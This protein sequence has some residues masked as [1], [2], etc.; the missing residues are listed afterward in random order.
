[1][2]SVHTTTQAYREQA[3]SCRSMAAGAP[4]DELR[5]QWFRLAESYERTAD[6][7]LPG[8]PSRVFA[9]RRPPVTL[10]PLARK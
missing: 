9:A 6:A 4:T 1:M 7:L 2:K 10:S 3:H 8:Q 5:R